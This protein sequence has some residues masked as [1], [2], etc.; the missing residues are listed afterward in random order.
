MGGTRLDPSHICCLPPC[1]QRHRASRSEGV[2]F[3]EGFRLGPQER[4][5]NWLQAIS[6]VQRDTTL[7]WNQCYYY[8]YYICVFIYFYCYVF[9]VCLCIFIVPAGTL[10][11]PWLRFFRAFPSVVRQMPGYNSQR[12]GTASTFPKFLWCSM[13]CL[14]CVVLC[15]DCV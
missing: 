13:Y 9:I 15:T 2:S 5:R 3:E 8:Y 14:F 12:W 11:L 6:F 1:G 7:A 4:G 10:R